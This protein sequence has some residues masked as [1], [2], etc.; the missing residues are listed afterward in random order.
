ME[1]FLRHLQLTNTSTEFQS[2]EINASILPLPAVIMLIVASRGFLIWCLNI[3]SIPIVLSKGHF[4][5]FGGKRKS[6]ASA[7]Q[8]FTYERNQSSTNNNILEVFVYCD[9]LTTNTEP[10]ITGQYLSLSESF[11]SHCGKK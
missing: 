9:N 4:I 7:R 5:I 3:L 2:L 11:S 1:S 10:L 8:D 6:D